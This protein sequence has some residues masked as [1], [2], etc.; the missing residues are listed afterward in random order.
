M[1]L[2][3]AIRFL[4]IGAVVLLAGEW[5]FRLLLVPAGRCA[6]CIDAPLRRAGGWALVV[7][8]VTWPGWL[9]AVAIGMSGLPAS[10]AL[11]LDVLRTVTRQTTFGRIWLLRAGLL[12]A[13]A[14]LHL[15]AS[16]PALRPR[17][18][19]LQAAGAACALASIAATGHA[20]GAH[21]EHLAIDAIHVLAAGLWVGMLAPL[22]RTIDGAITTQQRDL[23]RLATEATQ[24]FAMPG[25]VAVVAIAITGALNTWWQV[26]TAAALVSTTYGLLVLAKIGLFLLMLALAL[27]NRFALAARLASRPGADLALRRLRTT[28]L[29]EAGLGVLILGVVG[30]LGVMPPAAHGHAGH[31]M[32]SR[33]P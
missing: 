15:L 20:L 3:P 17:L 23:G 16:R 4:H 19:W 32:T 31:V 6:H 10:Q 12:L 28:V 14:A 27:V 2:L 30:V 33:W 8:L 5:A 1:E 11:G 24:R 9:A 25:A 13:L 18:A 29:V 22:W 21:R 7:A 26:G